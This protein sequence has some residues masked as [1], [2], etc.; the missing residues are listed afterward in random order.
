MFAFALWD[1]QDRIL[2][3]C[4]DQLGQAIGSPCM[5]TDI[6]DTATLGAYSIQKIFFLARAYVLGDD[7]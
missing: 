7:I 2:T 1:K 4:R 6:G 5:L 3:L